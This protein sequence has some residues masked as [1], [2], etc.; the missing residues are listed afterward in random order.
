MNEL[1]ADQWQP[2]RRR[3]NAFLS[4]AV[5]VGTMLLAAVVTAAVLRPRG[6][7]VGLASSAPSPSVSPSASDMAWAEPAVEESPSPSPSLTAAPSHT[8]IASPTPGPLAWELAP[9]PGT[10]ISDLVVDD[11]WIALS[12][13][14]SG[15]G[16]EAWLSADALTWHQGE[17]EIAPHVPDCDPDCGVG[18]FRAAPTAAVRLGSTL[19]AVGY[20]HGFSDAVHAAAW[21]SQDGRTWDERDVAWTGYLIGDVATNGS[22]LVATQRDYVNGSGSVWTSRDGLAWTEH[23]GPGGRAAMAA[24]W[25][26]ADGFVAVGQR[27]DGYGTSVE[28]AMWVSSDGVSWTEVSLPGG[29]GILVDVTR[30]QDGR[31]HV[32]GLDGVEQVATMRTWHSDDLVNWSSGVALGSTTQYSST[33][34]FSGAVVAAND[35]VVI[36]ADD[37]DAIRTWTSRDGGES[38]ADTGRLVVT[39]LDTS[40][41]DVE[42]DGRQIV[43]VATQVVW[44]SPDE[45][46]RRFLWI[47]RHQD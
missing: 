14:G 6:D 34:Q 32:V 31:Y 30:D 40:V 45:N 12:A 21:T 19:Y 25:G 41:V 3:R 10:W 5:V 4:I 35:E 22:V 47:R 7:E 36:V 8:T 29:G 16:G 39:E 33:W 20:W 1:V 11:G 2:K 13:A 43:V 46:P 18:G 28:P 42:T 9:I 26:D 38:W 24:I 44:P 27:G 15:P 17:I 23:T 37:H